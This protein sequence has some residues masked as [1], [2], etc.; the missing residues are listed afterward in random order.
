[1]HISWILFSIIFS[2]SRLIFRKIPHLCK[3]AIVLPVGKIKYPKTSN[4]FIPVALTPLVMKCFDK[5]VGYEL[6][7]ATGFRSLAALTG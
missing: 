3:E 6:L 4:D 5:L 7:L 1:M 2:R